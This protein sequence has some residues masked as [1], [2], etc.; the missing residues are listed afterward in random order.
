MKKIGIALISCF[1]LQ[2]ADGQITDTVAKA[3]SNHICKCIDTLDFNKS[4]TALKKDYSFCRTISL[5]NLLNEQ[6]LSPDV[7]TDE[8]QS[9]D[10]QKKTFAILEADCDAIKRLLNALNKEPDYNPKNDIEIFTPAAFFETYG[11]QPGEKNELLHVYNNLGK[12]ENKFQRVVDIRWTFA[13]E[14][15]ALKWHQM[16]LQKNS[17]GGLPVKDEIIIKGA[18]ELKVYREAPG[19]AEM[20]KAMGI[21]QRHHYF[22]FVY[23][24]IVCKVFVATDEKTETLEVIPF[25][26]AATAHL[27]TTGK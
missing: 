15:D 13:N 18:R 3:L 17:E 4:E 6:L 19:A 7:L 8:K 23:K 12:D 5:T 27:I 24:N 16:N 25:A 10:L 20:M 9:A 22:L 26:I 21:G 1:L 2:N 14:A 11:L